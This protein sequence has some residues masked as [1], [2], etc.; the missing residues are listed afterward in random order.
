LPLRDLNSP[1]VGSL[2]QRWTQ[3][4][5]ESEYPPEVISI[6][7]DSRPNLIAHGI[8]PSAPHAEPNPFPG[9]RFTP[10]PRG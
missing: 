7:Y 6:Y 5:R 1:T 8:I 4:L 10:D 3:F 9:F 2:A